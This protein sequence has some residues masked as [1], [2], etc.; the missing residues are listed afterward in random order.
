M[1]HPSL[2][3]IIPQTESKLSFQKFLPEHAIPLPFL[4]LHEDQTLALGKVYEV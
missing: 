2:R 4:E 3:G 1:M